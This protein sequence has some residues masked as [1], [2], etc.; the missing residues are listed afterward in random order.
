MNADGTFFVS[1]PP[2]AV[3]SLVTNLERFAPCV[4]GFDSIVSQGTDEIAIKVKVGVGAMKGT[5]N[6]KLRIVERSEFSV[7]YN[8]SSTGLGSEVQVIASF[9]WAREGGG[10]KVRWEGDA[11]NSGRLVAMGKALMESAAR[12]N[13]LQMMDNVRTTLD[14]GAQALHVGAQ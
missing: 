12:K 5:M 9:S 3:A 11:Q 10:T 2:E 13:I 14:A 1:A 7:C 6:A 4:P 8:G